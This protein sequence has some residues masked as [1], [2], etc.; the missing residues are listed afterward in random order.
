MHNMY[1]SLLYGKELMKITLQELRLLIGES[2][3]T[4]Q[5]E[6]SYSKH[7]TNQAPSSI[8]QQQKKDYWKTHRGPDA[9]SDIASQVAGMEVPEA[10]QR[11]LGDILPIPRDEW[12]SYSG[13]SDSDV[14]SEKVAY[15]YDLGYDVAYGREGSDLSSEDLDRIG[16]LV[17]DQFGF[18]WLQVVG[19]HGADASADAARDEYY[20]N[21]TYQDDLSEGINMKITRKQL[22]YIISEELNATLLE[23]ENHESEMR[24]FSRSKAGKKVMSAGKKISIAGQAISGVAD[25]QTGSMRKTLYNIS[26][27]VWKLGSSLSEINSLE[28]GTSA[29]NTLPTVKEL[30]QLHK[31]ILKLEK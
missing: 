7:K 15:L 25:E 8:R 2:L 14:P 19:G 9:R 1:S 18:D 23:N 17:Y 28:E 6:I 10:D 13:V 22:H 16:E 3:G 21:I 12:E 24:E 27:F 20:D 26:E 29:T 5:S 30:K 4:K 11:T 31:D